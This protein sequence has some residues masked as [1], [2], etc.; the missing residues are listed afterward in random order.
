MSQPPYDAT[1]TPVFSADGTGQKTLP[2]EIGHE[3]LYVLRAFARVPE[4]QPW[5]DSRHFGL[6]FTDREGNYA[7]H[8]TTVRP[9]VDT[10]APVYLDGGTYEV[11]VRMP[12]PDEPVGWAL[13]LW[14]ARSDPYAL[15]VTAT[16]TGTALL[17]PFAFPERTHFALDA[18][19]N[20]DQKRRDAYGTVSIVQPE[21]DVQLL[22]ESTTTTME[23]GVQG[24]LSVWMPSGETEWSLRV[25]EA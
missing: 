20:A 14:D 8:W 22:G 4:G 18:S 23:I 13:D 12:D 11:F 6:R 15:P 17:G 10:V 21:R 1:S 24:V 16:G 25:E 9:P 7:V 19:Y 3:G 5:D 2:V